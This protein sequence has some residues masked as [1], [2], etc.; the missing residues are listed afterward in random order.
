MSTLSGLADVAV[1]SEYR[2]V[3]VTDGAYALSQKKRRVVLSFGLGG[4][5]RTQAKPRKP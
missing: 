1:E 2:L 3:T 4:T 5:K